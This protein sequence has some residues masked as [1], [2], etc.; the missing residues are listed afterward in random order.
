MFEIPPG[1]LV[2]GTTAFFTFATRGY[3]EFVRN[4]HASLRRSDPILA[5][6]LIV[7]CADEATAAALSAA[8]LFTIDCGASE[9]PDFVEFERAG[10]GRI[11]SYKYVLAREL[12]R[13]AEFAWWCDG[14]IVVRKE[15]AGR[16]ASLMAV[17]DHDVLMQYEHPGGVFNAGFWVAR[18]SPSVDRM[19]EE[20]IE[21]TSRDG[22]LDDQAFFNRTQTHRDDLRLG[23]LDYDE[24]RCGNRFYFQR[25]AGVPDCRLL[26]FNY[27][28]G[29]ATKKGL[30]IGH[31]A[32]YL[33]EPAWALARA[34]LRHIGIALALRCGL[35]IVGGDVGTDVPGPAQRVRAL[36]RRVGRRLR[37]A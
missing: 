33:D 26:H 24:F 36:T 21:E 4:L 6:S 35:G 2:N 13:E 18:R 31:G 37:G 30:M 34:R 29:R 27:S 1:K 16:L 22:V 25:F 14:D 5:E 20:M 23:R 32:W 15:M 10:F 12:L 7:F 19:L 8:D 3:V 9:L 11:M 28:V 17:G